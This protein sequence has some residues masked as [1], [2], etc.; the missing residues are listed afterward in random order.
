M[1]RI[2]K[3]SL[4]EVFAF[5]VVFAL[6]VMHETGYNVRI[7]RSPGVLITPGILFVL[8]GFFPSNKACHFRD[9]CFALNLFLV[10]WTGGGILLLTIPG[11]NDEIALTTL[12]LI[13]AVL[14]FILH[15]CRILRHQDLRILNGL[16]SAL[17]VLTLINMTGLNAFRNMDIP[18][19]LR[20]F[21]DQYST[22][23]IFI[24]LYLFF[25]SM[26]IIMGRG[27][28][29]SSDT[30]P[31]KDYLRLFIPF[32]ILFYMFHT[33]LIVRKTALSHSSMILHLQIILILFLLFQILNGIFTMGK[34]FKKPKTVSVQK[35]RL[36]TQDLIDPYLT[37][38]GLVFLT[39]G[40]FFSE[41]VLYKS[42]I[43]TVMSFFIVYLKCNNKF[44]GS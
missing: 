1:N 19:L 27:Y 20:I 33:V 14:I 11:F 21:A 42:A 36:H 2:N 24:I 22:T 38:I 29:N 28:F 12:F 34:S 9:R 23:L 7:I 8:S 6:P 13:P 16:V 39:A 35:K 32:Q 40:F 3:T 25:P 37:G 44:Q 10:A 41:P 4:F 30:R 17:F 15:T 18:G 31:I 43:L 5:F 26:I